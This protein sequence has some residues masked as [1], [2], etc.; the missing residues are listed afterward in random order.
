MPGTAESVA[1]ADPFE[2][3]RRWHFTERRPAPAS[4]AAADSSTV[5]ISRHRVV[6]AALI[7]EAAGDLLIG[8]HAVVTEAA[9]ARARELGRR[10][11]RAGGTR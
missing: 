4:P 7:P 8:E 2:A 11:V 3:W 6:T 5:D 1:P 9:Q 10:L